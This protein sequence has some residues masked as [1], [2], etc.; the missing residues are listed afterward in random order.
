MYLYFIVFLQCGCIAIFLLVSCISL[1]SP[2]KT[3]SRQRKSYRRSVLHRAVLAVPSLPPPENGSLRQAAQACVQRLQAAPAWLVSTQSANKRP[4]PDSPSAP[5]PPNLPPLAQRIRSDIHV[6][7]SEVESPEKEI[8]RSSPESSP[9]PISP[10]VRGFPSPAPL[11]FTPSKV[12]CWNCD[13]DMTHDHQCGLLAPVSLEPESEEHNLPLCHYCC[14]LGSGDNPVHY[15]QQ[16]LCS[17]K[18]CN[19]RCYCTE[20]QLLH[21]KQFF[22][23]GFSGPM[24]PV[25]P[26]DRQDA[27]SIAE[28]R[29]CQWPIWPCKSEDCVR[30]P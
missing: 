6:G 24:V 10:C 4:L 2:K 16:C 7:D 14:H 9:P 29:I 28:K 13:G 17:E 5:S 25:D 18:T 30:P 3:S 23:D 12:Q 21:R 20:E 27:K 22:P 11:V 15:Y 1:A 8:L 26:L 19:C